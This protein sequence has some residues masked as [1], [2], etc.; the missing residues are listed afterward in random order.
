MEQTGRPDGRKPDELRP[1]TIIPGVLAYAEGSALIECGRTRVMVAASVED[2]VPPWMAGRGGG[3]ITAE[4]SMLPRATQTRSPRERGARIGGRTMEIQRLIGR[5]LRCVVDLNGFGE[6]TVTVDCDVLQA[7][8]GTRVASISAAWVALFQA[9]ERMVEQ[10]TLARNPVVDSVAAVSVGVRGGELLL[11]LD[12]AED[13]HADVDMNVVMTGSGNLVEIQATAEQEPFSLST[14][15]G[16][17]HLAGRG[18]LS[19][20]GLQKRVKD[21]LT[22]NSRLTTFIPGDIG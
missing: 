2:K 18:V 13:A 5:S 6:R 16:L 7:D 17:I 3:W 11:D 22:R 4:Y 9:F 15:D 10:G 1:W 8:G 19:I 20:T 14:L 12:Y 21:T